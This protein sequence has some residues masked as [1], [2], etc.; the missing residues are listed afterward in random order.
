MCLNVSN[1][2]ALEHAGTDLKIQDYQIP[3][4][5]RLILVSGHCF[6]I[7]NHDIT[8]TT[9]TALLYVHLMDEEDKPLPYRFH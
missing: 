8:T 1:S 2:N 6:D 7:Y 4:T 5:V 9:S 3:L